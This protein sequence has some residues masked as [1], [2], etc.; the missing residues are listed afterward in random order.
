VTD[1]APNPDHPDAARAQDHVNNARLQHAIA[2]LA[3]FG[4]RADGGV[5]RQTL[6]DIDLASR[7]HLIAHAR[8]L[9]CEVGIDDCANLFFRR[10]GLTDLA[11]VLTGSHGDT[12]P[13]GGKLDGA[14]GVLA[15]LEVIAALNTPTISAADNAALNNLLYTGLRNLGR[16]SEHFVSVRTACG[17]QLAP[18]RFRWKRIFPPYWIWI[19]SKPSA[20]MQWKKPCCR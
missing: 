10:K 17:A 20:S 18:I 8:D 19:I 1:A 5:S 2:E 15:G 12:Q 7:R 9:G 13:I 4:G 3:E 11:P 14:Y 16:I 6:T